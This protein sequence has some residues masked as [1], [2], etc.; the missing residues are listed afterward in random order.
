MVAAARRDGQDSQPLCD[1]SS[2]GVENG[3]QAASASA[4]K[5]PD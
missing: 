2:A 1:P 5:F 4:S 3:K